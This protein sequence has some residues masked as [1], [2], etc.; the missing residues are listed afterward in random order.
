MLC[1]AK[2]TGEHDNKTLFFVG[3]HLQGFLL[4]VTVTVISLGQ[5]TEV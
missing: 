5:L 2:L 1:Y 4:L 3:V